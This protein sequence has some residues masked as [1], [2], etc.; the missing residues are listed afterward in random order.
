MSKSLIAGLALAVG[1]LMTGVMA[2]SASA[3]PA[4]PHVRQAAPAVQQV[5]VRRHVER[6]EHHD[7]R[8]RRHY[9][10]GP[11]LLFTPSHDGCYWLKRRALNT[12]SRY[13]WHRYHECREG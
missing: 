13:W 11:V 4:V 2:G 1:M 9:N 7:Y 10:R 12:G 3:A 8:F 6:G 5:D